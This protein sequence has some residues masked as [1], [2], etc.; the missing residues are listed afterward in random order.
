M[1][2]FDGTGPEGQGKLT[3]RGLGNCN[4]QQ[5]DAKEPTVATDRMPLAGRGLGLGLGRRGGR[6]FRSWGRPMGGGRGRRGNW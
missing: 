6:G 2:R 1:P 3:G 5:T 4:I